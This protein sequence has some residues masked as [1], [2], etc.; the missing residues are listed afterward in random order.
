M[1]APA[2]AALYDGDDG[3]ELAIFDVYPTPT[4]AAS[5]AVSQRD[6]VAIVQL[7]GAFDL[8]AVTS[9]RGQF[10]RALEAG[11]ACVVDVRQVSFVDSAVLAA[12]LEAKHR[13]ERLR[14]PFVLVV[15]E[16]RHAVARAIIAACLKFECRTELADAVR[17]ARH[18]GP[19]TA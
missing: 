14:L 15:P 16:G 10:L 2:E 12:L 8:Y 6:G 3:E 13:S 11:R 5:I 19:A 1:S 9:M 18:G 4:D 7:D 17:I